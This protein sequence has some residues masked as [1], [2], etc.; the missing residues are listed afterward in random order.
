[1]LCCEIIH[2]CKYTQS[3]YNFAKTLAIY[4]TNVLHQLLHSNQTQ[5][6]AVLAE[7]N[8]EKFQNPDNIG[9]EA[10]ATQDIFTVKSFITEVSSLRLLC[11][12]SISTLTACFLLWVKHSNVPLV[13]SLADKDDAAAIT[14]DSCIHC[15]RPAGKNVEGGLFLNL[16]LSHPSPLWIVHLIYLS[17]LDYAAV[18][19]S[20][21]FRLKY[22]ARNTN[23]P[24]LASL[25]QRLSSI[26]VG[27]H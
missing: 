19:L 5:F 9:Q 8:V 15:Q 6:P 21:F 2:C 4:L 11:E 26:E 7:W 17:I 3:T 27:N 18:A 25:V 24:L 22:L 12:Q 1:M 23:L 10:S 13:F 20:C 14:D 16:F